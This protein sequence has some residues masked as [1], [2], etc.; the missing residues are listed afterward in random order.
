MKENIHKLGLAGALAAA[1]AASACCVGPLVLMLLGVSGAWIGTLTA[2]TPYQPIF[3]AL[4]LGLLGL[5]FYKTYNK[6]KAEQCVPGGYCASPKSG[7]LNKIVLWIFTAVIAGLLMFPYAVP[8][9]FA[10]SSVKET[11]VKQVTLEVKNMTCFACAFPVRKSLEKLDGVM[12]AKVT[13]RP[14]QA[15]VVYDP[16]KV[17]PEDM[18]RATT[19]AGYPSSVK[20]QE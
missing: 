9:V 18:T 5:A 4:A 1:I 14:P 13:T 15:V 19:N 10:E 2:L 7:R 6:P 11:R 20:K 17:T 12:S 3:T 16:A 8:Y